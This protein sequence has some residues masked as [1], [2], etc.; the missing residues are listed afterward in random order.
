MRV[1]SSNAY[2]TAV[3]ATV[4]IGGV[5]DTFT[6]TTKD[7]TTP[8]AFT[9]VDQTGAELSTA[10]AS[11]AVT[12]SGI[13]GP[14]PISVTGG[15]YKIGSGSWTATAGTIT[16]N[17]Q[18]QVRVT[19]SNAYSTAVS[20]TLTIGG[21]ADTFT[22][23]TKDDTVPDAFTFVDQTGAELNTATAAAAVTIT[24]I[25]G[26]SAISVTGG[27]YKIGS[28]S[29][30]ATAGTITNNQQAQVQVTS[31]NAYSTA[32]SAILTIGGV[33]DTFT[34]TTKDDTTPDAFTFVDQ[35][36]AELNTLTVSAAVT[37]S[38][39]TGPSPISVTGGEYK[40]GSGIWTSTAGTITNNQQLQVRV[41]SSNA[42][43]TA[44]S[45]TVTVGG[46][47]D[48]FTVTTKDDTVPDPFTFVDQTG[49]NLNAVTESA[50][51]TIT[52]I[53]GPSPI[54]VTG[55][56]YK[57]G[58][59]TWTADAGTVTNNQQVYVRVTS[60]NASLT[61]VSATLTIGTVSDTFMV[62]TKPDTTP[63][64]AEFAQIAAGTNSGTDP[65]FG[66]YSLTVSSAFYMGKYEVTKAKWDEVRTWAE[67]H[68][69]S[70]LPAGAGKAADHP[71]Q[72]VNWYDV[73]KWC[74]ARSEKEGRTP[75]YT[76]SGN[77]YRSGDNSG[78]I[79]NTAA[80]GYRLPTDVEW[81]YAARG[82]L[83]SKRFPWGDTITH[84]E[85]N[86]YSFEDY[87]QPYD[88]SPTRG[89]HPTYNTGGEPFTSPVGS[90]AANGYGLYD[91]AGNVSEWC[92]DGYPANDINLRVIRGSSWWTGYAS[93]CRA[94]NRDGD[95]PDDRSSDTHRDCVG[96]RICVTG[97][98]R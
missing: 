52:G 36:G 88:I 26:P 77:V 6:V 81:E 22:V 78:V 55:G 66:A 17:Q 58:A 51:V 91:M 7:D 44:V 59:G 20:A 53:T 42:Y 33:A 56:E 40:I 21:V 63:A 3:S 47:A 79:S 97:S 39:I 35:T 67:S 11:A 31:S 19:S 80:N 65:D 95:T 76:V 23:T 9:F 10:T 14:S 4:T 74:N 27:E 89:C 64:P 98:S 15:E 61:A 92:W 12:I 90:F 70:D 13:T 34:V 37:I 45:A 16:N 5:A 1:T 2:S 54:A 94:G 75:C 57:I 73:V 68:G 71:V 60:S 69:Y 83:T 50:A 38:G 93:G 49:A 82:G 86:Y 72:S 41:T 48:T 46:V 29:W 43:S 87:T 28:G 96:F 32:V 18:A 84:S 8:N 25:T 30:T 24:G 85:A 62:T